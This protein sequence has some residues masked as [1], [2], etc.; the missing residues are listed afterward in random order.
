M[1]LFRLLR[2]LWV[3]QRFGLDE[4]VLG[5]ERARLLRWGARALMFW[6]RLERPRG[7]RLRLALESLGPIFVKFGQMLSTRRDLIPADLA[8]ELAR[9]QDRVPPFSSAEA[10][11]QLRRAY[12]RPAAEVFAEFEREPVASAS[13]AQ[14]HRARLVSGEPCAVK[15]LRPG[16]RRVID[17]DLELLMAGAALVETLWSDGRR[18]KPREV[19]REFAKHLDDELDLIRE[20]ANCSQL[21]RNFESSPL[22]AV[23]EVYWDYCT[24]EVMVMQWMDGIPISR[25]EELERRGVDLKRL[26]RAGVEIFFT[27]VFRDGFFHADMHPGNILVEDSGRYVALDFGIMGTL[28]DTDKN[29]LAQNFL[30]FFRRDYKRV[31]D[32]HLEAGWVPPATRADE[33]EAAIRA[34]CEPVFDR[35]LKEIAFGRVLLRLFQTSRRFGM[36]IQPQLVMLQKTL[37]NIE[38]LG[39]ELDPDL[40]LWATAKPYLERWMSEQVGWRG[41][42]ARLKQ[43]APHWG[44]VMPQLPRLAHQALRGDHLARVEA[45]MGL[46]LAEQRRRNRWLMVI[47]GLLAAWLALQ[48]PLW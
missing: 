21:R 4:F 8:D 25:V 14:V 17:H 31:A 32:A 16:I 45:G 26:A 20:A 10:E 12:G 48:L 41:W 29:Y 13:V 6:R 11:A 15:I 30:A 3:A 34:V 19:V 9:L 44:M 22:L 39:R 33:F 1:R 23:P 24:H 28:N 2:I 47:A 35:P 46:L 5:H 36:E 27:Q 7:E 37:I 42:L 18:L 43:E 40:D 38:G